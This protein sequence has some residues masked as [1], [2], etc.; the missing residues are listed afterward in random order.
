MFKVGLMSLN[1]GHFNA[2]LKG[3]DFLLAN[4]PSRMGEVS[5]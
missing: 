4:V 5:R 1:M 2:G 3:L